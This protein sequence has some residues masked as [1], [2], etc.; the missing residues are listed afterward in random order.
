M[1]AVTVALAAAG[2]T[3]QKA[4]ASYEETLGRV[5]LSN[6]TS[7]SEF[8]RDISAGLRLLAVS[9][10]NSLADSAAYVRSRATGGIGCLNG[11]DSGKVKNIS[12]FL[13]GTHSF[14]E[15]FSGSEEERKAAVMLSDYAQ[16]LYYHLNDVTAAVMDGEY[17]LTEYSSVYSADE[18]LYFEDFL[19]FENGNENEIF[20]IITPASAQAESGS[21]LDG[22]EKI[23]VNEARKIAG[24]AAGMNPSLWREI[25]SVTTGVDVYSFA[26]GDTAAE[27]CK[28]GGTLCRLVN[29]LPCNQALYSYEYAKNKAL[30]FAE[31]HGYGELSAT[32][33]KKNEFTADFSMFPKVNGILLLTARIEATVCL[34]SGEITY[35]DA[36]EYIK[37]YRSD[38]IFNME[39]PNLSGI[40]PNNLTLGE[41]LIC[42]V[43]IGGRE[44]ICYLAV[45][46]FEG[47]TVLVFVDTSEF[48]VLKTKIIYDTI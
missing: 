38:I 37:N 5:R 22:K 8:S 29:P 36:S 32:V 28:S 44:R 1:S 14:A 40:L 13:N 43:N 48:K 24:D 19:D 7:L 10:D 23:S 16:S 9:A 15:D 33:T 47:D 42:L 20:K 18:L 25:N 3:A 39:K 46:Y 4:K 21:F 12:E 6:L 17:S 26:H 35:F 41:T 27:I 45:C 31:K 30:E 2:L 11:F 34:S